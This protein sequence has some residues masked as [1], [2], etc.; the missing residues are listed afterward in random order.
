[1]NQQKV[2]NVS[3]AIAKLF[4]KKKSKKVRSTVSVGGKRLPN[5]NKKSK[6]N[7]HVQKLKKQNKAKANEKISP[8]KLKAKSMAQIKRNLKLLNIKI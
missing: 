5:V 6:S 4:A 8:P 1:M 3:A 7:S 2:N